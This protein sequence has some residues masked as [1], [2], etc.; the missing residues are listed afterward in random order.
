MSKCFICL[1]L[2]SVR[3]K[4]PVIFWAERGREGIFPALVSMCTLGFVSLE[5]LAYL[6]G[7]IG[8]LA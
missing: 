2:F 4:D 1:G 6:I 5:F 8:L 3:V 7:L